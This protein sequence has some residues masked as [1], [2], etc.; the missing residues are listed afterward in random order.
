MLRHLFMGERF[1]HQQEA[2]PLQATALTCLLTDPA[3]HTGFRTSFY[4]LVRQALRVPAGTVPDMPEIH[5]M[6]LFPGAPDE[7]KIAFLEGLADLA[8]AQDCALYRI[9]YRANRHAVTTKGDER[10][11][12]ALCFL[13]VRFCLAETRPEAVIW[14]VMELD[15]THGRQDLHFAGSMQRLDWYAHLLGTEPLSIDNR[16]FGEVL[17]HAKASAYGAMV[18]C[19]S[20]LLH[21]RFR[22]DS[23]GPMTPFKTRLAHIADR[24]DPIV[25][26]DEIIDLQIGPPPIGYVQNGPTRFVS[27][28]SS[29]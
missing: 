1:A 7:R 26:H 4:T 14:P 5:G 25:Q 20:Y 19:C 13:S 18:D 28:L 17:Y 6:D 3:R 15:R 11:V 23:G 22:R 9:G 27:P 8:V 2:P 10:D 29:S 21:L 24:L 16:Q 12:L